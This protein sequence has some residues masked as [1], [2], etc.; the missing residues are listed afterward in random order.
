MENES[1]VPIKKITKEKYIYIYKYAEE[2]IL[3]F[4]EGL[5]KSTRH[6]ISFAYSIAV[7]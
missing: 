1:E 4:T 6:G 2:N 3:Y 7:K 5:Y